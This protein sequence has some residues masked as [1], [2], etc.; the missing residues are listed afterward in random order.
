MIVI[1][2]IDGTLCRTSDVDDTCWCRAASEILGVGA[3]STDWG[4]YPHSTDESIACALIR[5]HRNEEPSRKLLDRL[6]DRFFELLEET[7]ISDPGQFQATP[8]ATVLM[9]LLRNRGVHLAV[10]TGGWRCSAQFK[11]DCA[12][13]PHHDL[14]AAFADDAHPRERII[15]IAMERAAAT[16]GIQ[17]QSLGTAVYVGDGPWDVRAARGL[18]I[19]FIGVATGERAIQLREQGALRVFPDFTDQESFLEALVAF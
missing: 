19:E 5:E 16:A 2:D 4:D 14:P 11:L 13:I 3:M 1:F 15:T 7:R 10:A 8:G 18:G 9:D 6:R 12:G 17:L